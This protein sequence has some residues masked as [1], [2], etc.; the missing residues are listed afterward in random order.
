MLTKKD[1]VVGTYEEELRKEL[2]Y[3]YKRRSR[4]EWLIQSLEEC[5]EPSGEPEP[6]RERKSA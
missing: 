6:A 3:L 4:L 5:E 2:E 1:L